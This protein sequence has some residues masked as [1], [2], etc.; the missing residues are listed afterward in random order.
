MCSLIEKVSVY[1][2]LKYALICKT[3]SFYSDTKK[4]SVVLDLVQYKIALFL[5][6]GL[7]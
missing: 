2:F 1:E 3:C 7:N 5:I 4:P 6:D